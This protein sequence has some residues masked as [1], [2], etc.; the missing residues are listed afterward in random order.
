MQHK[1]TTDITLLVQVA[2]RDSSSGFLQQQELSPVIVIAATNFIALS[3]QYKGPPSQGWVAPE[4]MFNSRLG[5]SQPASQTSTISAN[6][7]RRKGARPQ[8]LDLNNGAPGLTTGCFF[9]KLEP[10]V[11]KTTL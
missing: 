10:P 2:I 8:V 3:L 7:L 9:F 1:I 11:K 4:Y 6:L 5:S